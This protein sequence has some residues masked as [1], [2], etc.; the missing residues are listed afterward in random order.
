MIKKLFSLLILSLYL[1][2]YEIID[3]ENIYTVKLENH[4]FKTLYANLRDEINFESFTIVHELHLAKSTNAVAQALEKKGVLKEGVNILMCKSS[5]T[6]EMVEENIENITYC[7]MGISVYEDEKY[8][9]ISFKKSK[10]FDEGN[11][12]ADEINKKL[13]K[14]ILESLD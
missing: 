12:I 3:K 14:I 6:L 11:K 1:N 7:P 2:A 9:Y 5:F 13:E 4:D 8:Q 10:S